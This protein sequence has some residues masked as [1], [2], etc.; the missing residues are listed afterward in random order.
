[1]PAN[2]QQCLDLKRNPES[3]PP[4]PP[5]WKPVK[6]ALARCN[7]LPIEPRRGTLLEVLHSEVSGTPER[8]RDKTM[9][10]RRN[11]GASI[12]HPHRNGIAVP[13][14]LSKT[15]ARPNPLK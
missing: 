11:T 8:E 13:A 5:C 7:R 6:L 1:V 9:L 2:V 10:Q 3:S 12:N 14:S 15:N 4:V